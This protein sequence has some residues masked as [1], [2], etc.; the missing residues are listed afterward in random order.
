MLLSAIL[1]A[2][3]ARLSREI[4]NTNMICIVFD[5]QTTGQ[6]V[7][8]LFVEMPTVFLINID[9]EKLPS[10]VWPKCAQ[11]FALG[12][13]TEPKRIVPLLN[14]EITVK[15]VLIGNG[16]DKLYSFSEFPFNVPV[17]FVPHQ[18]QYSRLQIIT[19]KP[20][21]P[22]HASTAIQ[23]SP[24]VLWNRSDTRS[25]IF[26]GTVNWAPETPQFYALIIPPLHIHAG[27]LP[28]TSFAFG[29]HILLAKLLSHRLTGDPNREPII[30]AND[31]NYD[32][33][34][35]GFFDVTLR[36]VDFRRL[37]NV[38]DGILNYQYTMDMNSSRLQFRIEA[39]HFRTHPI[40]IYRILLIVPY[41]PHAT[42]VLYGWRLLCLAVWIIAILILSHLRYVIEKYFGDN[43]RDRNN[44]F[45]LR[46]NYASISLDSF[47]R[48]LNNSSSYKG[49]KGTRAPNSC[50]EVVI[51]VTLSVH[52][53]FVCSYVSGKWT[54]SLINEM[55]AGQTE[56][57]DEF[58]KDSTLDMRVPKESFP[59][60]YAQ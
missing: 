10:S 55:S 15:I 40:R 49:I 7:K 60:F 13:L 23:L 12:I 29:P 45:S 24:D 37:R 26:W 51:I 8:Q 1:V 54:Q 16:A 56:S 43:R 36:S 5:N 42:G 38:R 52:A 59:T 46:R 31:R 3:L 17:L 32:N 41:V 9:T 2:F 33:W 30:F 25:Q 20:Y 53:F 27:R 34:Y 58:V 14:S 44:E 28:S 35:P 19:W 48:S 21:V 50:A 39:G 22:V 18:P 57:F 6:Q 4:G 11:T 47:A